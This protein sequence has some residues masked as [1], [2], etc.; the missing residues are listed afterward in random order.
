MR[1]GTPFLTIGKTAVLLPAAFALLAA[2]PAV[3]DLYV[4]GAVGYHSYRIPAL[5]ATKKG[6]LLAFCEARKNSGRD[7]GDIDMVVRRSRDGGKTWSAMTRV[8][9]EGG[10]A[11]I[12]IGN[13]SPVEDRRTGVIHLL[14]ARNNQR[15]FEKH[16]RDEGVT[17]SDAVEI[18]D[19][20]R[21]FSFPWARV[22]IGPG[23]AIQLR[24]GRLLVPVWLND[25]I[26]GNYRSAALYSDDGGAT[27]KSGGIV[28]PAA[29]TNANECMI[30]ERRDGAVV[31]SLRSSVHQRHMSVSRDGGLTWSEPTAVAGVPDPVCQ[32]SILALPKGRVV[33]ANPAS[34]SRR[35][36]MTLRL[37]EDGGATWP[38]ARA[39]YTGPSG[40][41]DLAAA[42]DGSILCLFESG[43]KAPSERIQFARI[44]AGWLR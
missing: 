10:D 23:H 6:T 27:W 2:D 5:L 25:R 42:R 40:Y 41:S 8:H 24:S 11:P 15:V 36:N 3:T 14:F 1:A 30:F 39:L 13:P 22:G 29:A 12:T 26:K 33:F 9:E 19:A 34:D 38:I 4:G 31:V 44:P 7:D 32:A 35:V 28:P 37:S 21:G 43:V 16:S 17:W 18:T 20:L